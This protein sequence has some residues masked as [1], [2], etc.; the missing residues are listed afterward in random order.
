MSPFSFGAIP[1]LNP[2]LFALHNRYNYSIAYNSF[3]PDDPYP[4][5]FPNGAIVVMRMV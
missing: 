3:I 5:P 1:N 4:H 2:R